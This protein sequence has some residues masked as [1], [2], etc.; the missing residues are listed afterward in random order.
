MNG[1]NSVTLN[2]EDKSINIGLT[3]PVDQPVEFNIV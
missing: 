1:I 2:F 3:E